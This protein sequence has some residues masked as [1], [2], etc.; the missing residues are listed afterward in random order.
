MFTSVSR[1]CLPPPGGGGYVYLHQKVIITSPGGY[2]FTSVCRQDISKGIGPIFIFNG[3]LQPKMYHLDGR[4]IER[5]E[6]NLNLSNHS[7][8]CHSLTYFPFIF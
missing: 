5:L 6:P 8:C 3:W 4:H 1:L 7:V 2:V